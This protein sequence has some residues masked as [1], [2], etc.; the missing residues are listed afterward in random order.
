M[1]SAV[2]KRSQS[3]VTDSG[4]VRG[5]LHPSEGVC[6]VFMLLETVRVTPSEGIMGKCA[7]V[8]SGRCRSEG[9]MGECAE[10][11]FGFAQEC[12]I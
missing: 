11:S 10:D 5:N 7:V 9:I 8:Y 12:A 4:G 3:A 6:R 1:I 2:S